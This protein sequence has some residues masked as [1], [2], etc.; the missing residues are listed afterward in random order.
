MEGAYSAK[1]DDV[2]LRADWNKEEKSIVA[3]YAASLIGP[4]DFVYLDA[5]TTTGCMIRF[6]TEKRAVF[7]TNAVLHARALAHNGFQV[8]LIGGELKAS[9]EAVVGNEALINLEK[10]NFTIGFFG[11]NGV[12]RHNGFTTP[13]AN[14]A[15]VKQKAMERCRRRYIL[16][17]ASKFGCTSPVTFA[18][19]TSAQVITNRLNDEG[20]RDCGNLLEVDA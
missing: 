7:V 9:T 17:D 18:S 1:D 14:E 19:F 2:E 3:R 11:A 20:Y 8:F 12:S 6:L 10:Y 4:E 5:G 15:I 16:C 13:D